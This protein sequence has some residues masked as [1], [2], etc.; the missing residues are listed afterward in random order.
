MTTDSVKCPEC[1]SENVVFSKKRQCHV[2]EDCGHEFDI[3]KPFVPHRVFISYGHDEHATLAIRL[4]DDLRA[5]GHDPWFDEE[6][7]NLGHDWEA[8]IERG[9]AWAAEGRP[10]AAVVLL[11]TP[12]SVRRPDGYCLNEVA[13]ALMLGLRIIPLMVVESEP[14]LSICRVQWLDMREC[15]PIHEKEALYAPKFERLLAALERDELDFEGTQSRLLRTLQPIQFSA[16]LLKLLRDFTGRQWVFDEVDRWFA[17]PAGAKVFWLTGAP[18]VGKSAI[19]AW[20][21]EHRREVAAFHFCDINSEEKRNPAK[22]VR[23]IAYQLSTQIPEYEARL[24]RLPLES[25][26]Q[27]YHEAY[28]LFDKL[29]VQPL[30]DALPAPD[31]SIVVLIDALDE[32]TADRRNEIVLLLSRC[33]DKTPSW[34]RF[35]VTSRPEPEIVSAFRALAPYVLDTAKQ[36]NLDDLREYLRAQLPGIAAEQTAEILRR[37]EGVF[38][39]VAHVVEE[40]R[41]GTLSLAHIEDFPR[42]LG[43]VYQR[44]FQRQF[45]ADI[46]EYETRMAPMLQA[47]FAA[48]EPLTLVYLKQLCG[49]EQDTELMRRL[50][51]LGSLFPT[52]GEGDG[53]TIRPF[54]RSLREWITARASAGHFVIAEAD[55]H[56]ALAEQGLREYRRGADALSPYAIR[57]LPAHLCAISLWDDLIGADATPG[58]LSDLLFIQAKCE[59]GL[60]HDLMRDY[61]EALVSLPEFREENERLARRD[62]AMFAYNRALRDYAVTRCDWWFAKERGE[63]R[64]EPPYPPLPEELQDEAQHAIPEAASP[65]AARLRHFANFVSGNLAPL[66]QRPKDTLP[67]AYNWAD[68]GPVAVQAGMQIPGRKLP[69]LKRSPRPPAPPLRPQC[70]RT[71]EGHSGEVESVSISPDG[72]RAV[73]GSTDKTL[74]VWDLETG[75]CLHTLIGHAHWVWSVSVSSD[76]RHVIS[77]S[78]DGIRR[79]W[80]LE[81][82]Q[83]TLEGHSFIVNSVSVSPDR[84][85]A[86][87]GCGDNT[88][89]VWDLETGQCLC[90][91]EG[92]AHLVWS[93]SVSPDGRRAV[94]GS[95]D[96]TLRV[97]DIE[98]GQCLRTLE[99]HSNSIKSVDLSPDGRR[100]V[101]GSS[102]RTI[103]LWDLETGQCL[104][105]LEGHKFSVGSVS[106]SPDGRRAVSGSFDK[107]VRLWDLETG[108]CQ[109]TLDG[110]SG[111]VLSVSASPDGRRAASSGSLDRTVWLWDL[112]T[113]L[114]L[115]TLKG[116]SSVVESLSVSPDGRHAISGSRD[117][118]VRFWDLETDLC[119][120]TLEGHN[121]WVSSV[122]VS[123]D[124]R[125][126]V[127][128]SSDRTVRLW[129]LETG[130]CLCTLK[131]PRDAVSVSPECRRVVSGSSDNTVRLW[132]METDQCLRT[133]EGHS[134]VVLSVS[135]SPDGRRAVSGSSDRTVRLW[136]LESGQGLRTLEGHSGSVLSVNVSPDGR[137]AVSGSSDNTVRLWNQETGQCLAVHPVRSSV[138]S[139]LFSPD[140]H[141]IVCG[142][143][144][145]QIHFL[146]TVN[147]T[148][149]PPILTPAR[150][151]HFGEIRTQADNNVIAAPGRWDD[152]LTVLCP[153]C[154]R[155]CPVRDDM[156][157]Q[158]IACPMQSCG[159]ALQLN[160]FVVDGQ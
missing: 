140:G 126:A 116:L 115:R 60:V 144:M 70:L 149:G 15:I 10:H 99:E 43:D 143:I 16:D 145:G 40:V 102:D 22:L 19:A 110:H 128:G 28:T 84:R 134:N 93:V 6:R 107:T 104:R 125:G 129:D 18:G 45:G 26:V 121:H 57:H 155:R 95:E 147:V 123:P 3:E 127:S 114:C 7:L 152:R 87:S 4:R 67:V 85:R 133:L 12:H 35:L 132:D 62:A 24:A 59:A 106:V 142:T 100:A 49:I 58:P 14:P 108:Q 39:Y 65:R 117:K 79:V 73:S 78:S 86:V 141:R 119:L 148:S 52:T 77:G 81:T 61:N 71:L 139:V 9:L 137:Y 101:S 124:G 72:R 103:R 130:Q 91:L 25:I 20:V 105:T 136:D 92:H 94:S 98:T 109:R 41:A 111:S 51:R 138:A 30:A 47:I 17:N 88:L 160:P 80:D 75:Q 131:G 11:L 157:G 146:T 74:R 154:G 63:T 42:S 21:R 55:G 97:W 32:A 153:W 13:R 27:E 2:C 83:C 150:L 89:R 48:R 159:K 122:S 135:V 82:G 33:A 112:E 69:W 50:N 113:G 37:S 120:R 64:P 44:F 68:A 66:S 23:S 38:L 156:V 90:T 118:T 158:Q 29:L 8:S 54:H 1:S 34:L 5:Y 76:G 31:R 46:R 53:D 36:E 96:K 56:R 151:W